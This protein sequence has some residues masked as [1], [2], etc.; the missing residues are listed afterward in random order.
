MILKAF[1]IL[2]TKANIFN[3]PF[4]LRT[5]GE[6]VRAFADL[7]NDPQSTIYRHP[8]DYRL[9]LCGEFDQDHGTF[10]A[11]ERPTPLGSAAEFK[12]PDNQLNFP[13]LVNDKKES[14]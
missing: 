2:D 9:F 4:M 11:M 7:S 10:T 12:K 13:Q 1:A 3:T 8:D 5:T 6:A 14:A